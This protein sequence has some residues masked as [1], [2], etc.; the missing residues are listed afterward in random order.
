MIAESVSQ[1]FNAGRL[2]RMTYATLR[3]FA[4]IRDGHVL[5]EAH[6]GKA[7]IGNPYYLAMHLASTRPEPGLKL[8]CVSDAPFDR[9]AIRMSR[10]RPGSFRYLYHLATAE[11][12]VNDTS[13]PTYFVRRDGQ[14]YLNT[15][16]GTPLK[17]L[18]RR[19]AMG[20]FA[21][22]QNMQRNLMQA[23]HLLVPNLHTESVLV[24]DFML[25]GWRGTLVRCGYPRNDVLYVTRD[26]SPP[27]PVRIAFMP[28]WRG[29]HSGVNEASRRHVSELKSLLAALDATLPESY[30]VRVKLH[31]MASSQLDFSTFQRVKAFPSDVET[32][33]FLATCHAL[34][35]DYSSVMFDFALTGRPVFLHM[36][37]LEHYR[38]ERNFCLGL[39]ELPFQQSRDAEGLAS[40][41]GSVT[42]DASVSL[43]ESFRSKFLDWE[44]GKSAAQVC[45]AYFNQVAGGNERLAPN[46]SPAHR[47][48]MIF[49]RSTPSI[50][51]RETLLHLSAELQEA[52][53]EVIVCADANPEAEQA[54]EGF[55]RETHEITLIPAT[56][57]GL[58][59]GASLILGS[60][61]GRLAP[62]SRHSRRLQERIERLEWRRLF[63]DLEVDLIIPFAGSV[64]DRRIRPR[65]S[66]AIVLHFA[67][68][69]V[70]EN[71]PI[72]QHLGWDAGADT[73]QFAV[74]GFGDTQ[75]AISLRDYLLRVA[76]SLA[77]S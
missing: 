65:P 16:H 66:S 52:G 62:R 13:F 48:A 59:D 26:I 21:N 10:C 74:R 15:W 45:E 29:T 53:W 58:L 8:I 9:T 55:L 3:R 71:L 18:G 25:T 44:T 69:D 75:S 22:L 77:A 57:G 76:S 73:Q 35:T 36:P 32:Y 31:P 61:L 49:P 20:V 60:V 54:L 2:A 7:L 6:K 11:Y 43:P 64:W 12:L 46:E 41:L 1:I 39:N 50:D 17:S 37:D 40:L 23:T 47:R 51:D 27:A 67:L 5:L 72:L 42:P 33:E 14:R 4:S 34:V 68:E 38:E 19:A 56:R 63:G 30:E 28:T 24:R 70:A